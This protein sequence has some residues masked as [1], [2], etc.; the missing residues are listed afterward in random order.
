M[1]DHY[2]V[3]STLFELYSAFP[4]AGDRH[5]AEFFP[6][7]L[8]EAANHG[9]RYGVR[10]TPIAERYTW[11]AE[12]RAFVERLRKI[13]GSPARK[14]EL[15]PL[16]AQDSGEAAAQII[17]AITTGQQY[18]G[19]LNLPNRGQVDGLPRE[20]VV[21]TMGVIDPLGGRGLTA[22]ELP[23]PVLAVLSR[24]VANQEMIVR[25]GLDGDRKMAL[26]ALLNDPLVSEGIAGDL[27]AAGK[28]LDEL[29]T[30]NRAY[31]PRFWN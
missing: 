16:M 23:P 3:K 13:A 29:L 14:A 21:E 4:A 6:W 24:H 26:Q 15:E 28:M 9:E 1:A 31:L 19:I 20:A 17:A 5:V 30:A 27:P 18:Q 8:N 22:G 7:F 2:R 12:A 25:A 10:R 11:R